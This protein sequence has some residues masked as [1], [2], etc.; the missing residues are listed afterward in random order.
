M[1]L[2]PTE[3]DATITEE[4]TKEQEAK[5]AEAELQVAD[6]KLQSNQLGGLVRELESTVKGEVGKQ[7][8]VHFGG[9]QQVTTWF[10]N[11]D[12]L[13]EAMAMTMTTG[14]GNLHWH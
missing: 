8:C 10:G 5:I 6:E 7:A 4:S 11:G 1:A 9:S 13:S 12:R 2:Q 3:H 14:N